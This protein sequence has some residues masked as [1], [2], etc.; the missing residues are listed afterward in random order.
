M[1]P[2]DQRLSLL[3]GRI[4]A[5]HPEVAHELRLVA[6]EVRRLEILNSARK[7]NHNE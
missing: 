3:A 7:G 5:T 2:P 4:A 1:T 6:I